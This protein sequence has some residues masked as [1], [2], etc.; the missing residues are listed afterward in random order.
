[1]VQQVPQ[2]PVVQAVVV[3]QA[4]VEAVVVVALAHSTARL[5]IMEVAAHPAAAAVQDQLQ[6]Q[7]GP[8][9]LVDKMLV[10]RARRA[11]RQLVV[12]AAGQGFQVVQV[13]H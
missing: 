13:V 6:E 4:V 8:A 1:V 7:V 10:H 12:L 3:A 5:H 11:M 9:A 2:V